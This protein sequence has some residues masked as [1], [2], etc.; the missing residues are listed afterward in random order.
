MNY[1]VKV[2]RKNEISRF[3]VQNSTIGTTG[4]V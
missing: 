1:L 4:A 3:A 2:K